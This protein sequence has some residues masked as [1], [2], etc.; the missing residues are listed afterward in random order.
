MEGAPSLFEMGPGGS[1]VAALV[2]V[3]PFS[4]KEKRSGAPAAVVVTDEQGERSEHAPLLRR[5][6]PR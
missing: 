3:R 4:K 5:R 6:C 1:A 2:R